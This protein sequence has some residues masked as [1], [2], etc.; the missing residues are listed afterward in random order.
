M[1]APAAAPL[2][3]AAVPAPGAALGLAARGKPQALKLWLLVAAAVSL[4]AVGWASGDLPAQRPGGL[5]LLALLP[6]TAFVTLLGQPPHGGN[7]GA[8]LLRWAAHGPDL[9]HLVG[10]AT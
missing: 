9:R 2:L 8:W 4:G 7:A 6:L 3:L 1:T 5:F 10:V